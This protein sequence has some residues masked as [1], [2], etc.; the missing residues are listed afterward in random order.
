MEITFS[1]MRPAHIDH[2]VEIEKA[3]F[4]T[5]WS[6]QSFSYEVLNNSFARYIVALNGERVVGYAGMWLI[7]DE[8]H[9]TNLAVHPDFR[10]KSVGRALMLE[11]MRLAFVSG[12]LRIMLEVRPSNMPARHLYSSLGFYEQG[13][14]R[15]YYTDN[16]EDAIIMWRDSLFTA[17][18]S[19]KSNRVLG[20][21]ER[22]Y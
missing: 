6:R 17:D 22:R 2:V 18:A 3:S 7:L 21:S 8:A 12:V 16:G 4:P 1:E 20:G 5:P 14:R 10:R 9:I 15:R 19:K 11:I 13:L